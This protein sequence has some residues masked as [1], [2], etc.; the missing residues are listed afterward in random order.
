M[1]KTLL[2]TSGLL[3]SV[4]T[5]Q[6]TQADVGFSFGFGSPHFGFGVSNM[7]PVP[8]VATPVVVHPCGH[9]RTYVAKPVVGLAMSIP[10]QKRPWRIT[11]E[12]SA[13]LEVMAGDQWITI[14]PGRTKR[15]A[16]GSSRITIFTACNNEEITFKPASRT[17]SI[18]EDSYGDILYQA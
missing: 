13:L 4:A 14:R 16:R 5:I 6:H 10:V 17:F 9:Y 8:V 18:V 12:T 3:L 2:I 11:N 1:N 7:P 15:I